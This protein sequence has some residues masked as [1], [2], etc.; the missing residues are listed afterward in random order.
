MLS[1]NS[2]QDC[3]RMGQPYIFHTKL[4]VL[5]LLNAAARR[6][7]GSCAHDR[8]DVLANE[9]VS[10][11]L[12]SG[13]WVGLHALRGG[14]NLGGE[15]SRGHDKNAKKSPEPKYFSTRA[16]D[17]LRSAFQEGAQDSHAVSAQPARSPKLSLQA[18][19]LFDFLLSRMVWR[20]QLGPFWRVVFSP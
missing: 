11:T 5:L 16:F 1:T 2:L 12:S 10:T 15:K 6:T 18:L 19:K 20:E 7:I 8:L 17:N 9:A 14:G 3:G 13:G 4:L